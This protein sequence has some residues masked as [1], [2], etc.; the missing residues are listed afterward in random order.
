MEI[1]YD[2]HVFTVDK[3]TCETDVVVV[4]NCKEFFSDKHLR[5]LVQERQR[6]NVWKKVNYYAQRKKLKEAEKGKDKD[7]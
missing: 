4:K 6:S 2:K 1:I 5:G 3:K 7:K